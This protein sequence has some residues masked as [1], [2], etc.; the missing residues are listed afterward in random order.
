M[1]ECQISCQRLVKEGFEHY[2]A[3]DLFEALAW[4]ASIVACPQILERRKAS[5]ASAPMYVP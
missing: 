2:S 5:S 4:T 3:Q 1:R